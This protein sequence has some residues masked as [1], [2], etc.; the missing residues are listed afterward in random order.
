M[1]YLR[2]LLSSAARELREIGTNPW[3]AITGIVMPLIW[4]AL[5]IFVMGEGLMRSLPVGLADEDLSSASRETAM[6]LEAIP[7]VRFVRYASAAA[8]GDDL[9]SGKLYGLIVFPKN[10][11][12]D[13]DAGRPSSAIEVHLNKTYYA[14]ATVLEFDI[15]SALASISLERLAAKSSAAGAGARG[16]SERLFTLRSDALLAGNSN[17]NYSA[18][19]LAT[20][21]PGMLS[22][23]AILTL[24]GVYTRDVRL[25]TLWD[26]TRG[27]TL[28]I[29]AIL[30][31]RTLPWAAI[32]GLEILLYVLWFTGIAGWPA[33]GSSALLAAG[34]LLFILAFAAF[35]LLATAL[36]PSWI[37][38]M[39]AAICYCAPIFP[40]TGFSYPLESMDAAARVLADI[41]PLTWLLKLHAAEVAIGAPFA[42][43]A[44]FLAI[45]AALVLVPGALGLLV[46]RLK[47]PRLLAAEARRSA[48]PL[49]DEAPV[50][51]FFSVGLAA[52][53]RAL[54][55]RDTFLIFSGAIAF[56]LV[57]YAWPYANQTLTQIPAAIVDLDRS[58]LSRRLITELDA[59]PAL[60]IKAVETN[61]AAARALYE[62]QA[63]S[64][65]ITIDQN[66][67]R[68]LLSGKRS[69]VSLTASGTFP[70]KGRALQAAMMGVVQN[71]TA[72]VA[73]GNLLRAGADTETVLKIASSPVSFT[74]ENRFNTISGYATY[75]VPFVVPII[76]QAVLLT[77]IA[78]SVGGWISEKRRNGIALAVLGTSRGFWGLF[79]GFWLYAM[80]W[81]GYA[82]GWDFL[83][84]D[85]PAGGNPA[86]SLVIS[87]LYAACIV[88]LGL[89]VTLAM[90]TNA[91][92]AQFMVMIS[93][94][95]VFLAGVVYPAE[96]FYAPARAVSVLLPSTHAMLGLVAAAQNNASTAA[97][98]PRIAVL[99]LMAALLALAAYL[100]SIRRGRERGWRGN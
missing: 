88:G 46:W 74:A 23:A 51:G 98:L 72:A 97:V 79:F 36:A 91:Y 25:G 80:L 34:A 57:F 38:A 87:A 39:S 4:V 83:L 22:L 66:F 68:D 31:G 50:E 76:L 5:T 40:Y 10:W 20:L 70:V 82:Q 9:A 63:V 92:G 43:K 44:Q 75:I 71:L 1:H 32:F 24:V 58:A 35:P 28:P 14:I 100:L 29:T 47:L 11:S 8:A 65:V 42:A 18:Y 56:Y 48:E 53:R 96:C 3:L 16:A 52:I 90:N 6:Q 99:A 62:A 59:C 21:I 2:T 77:G 84:F 61:P 19:L 94:P 41:F 27:G 93:A 69:A 64:G 89:T 81:M 49:P 85:F 17:F 30:L 12:A 7:S 60:S 15:K 13:R 55:N 45:L 67:E 78:L 54:L 86:A 95:S 33:T 37:L 26:A 73:A